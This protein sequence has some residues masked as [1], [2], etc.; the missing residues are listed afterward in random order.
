M[1]KKSMIYVWIFTFITILLN[2]PTAPTYAVSEKDTLIVGMQD[3]TLSLDPAKAYEFVSSGI[4]DQMY[5]RLVTLNKNDPSRVEPQLAESW[6]ISDDGKTWTFYLRKGVT[7]A[8]GNPVNAD[9]VVFSLGRVVKLANEV[10][11]LLTQ[12]GITESS[13]TKI[14]EYTVQTVLDDRYAPGI[15][16]SCL[17]IQVGSILDPKIVMEHEQDG[18]MG[19]AWLEEHSA[20]S[21]LFIL[22]Q[23]KH[24]ESYTLTQN[25]RYWGKKPA[26]KQIIVKNIQEPIDQMFMLEKGKIDIAWDLQPDQVRRLETNLD[27]QIYE[28]PTF[29]TIYVTMNQSYEPLKKPEVRDAIR[30]AIDYDGIIDFILQGA[31]VRAQTFLP[32]GIFNYTPALSYDYDLEKAKSLLTQAGYPDGFEVELACFDYSPWIDIAIKIKSDLTR[33]GINAKV[34]QMTANQLFEKSWSREGQ[35][36]LTYWGTDYVDPDAN[37][38]AFAHSDSPEDDATIQSVVWLTH[39][40]NLET[41]KLVGQASRELEPEK[42]AELYKEISDIILDDG[43]FAFLYSP[44]KQYGVRAEVRDVIGVPSFSLLYFPTLR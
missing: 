22:E 19:S 37:A 35:L 10:S 20:G 31:A 21:G 12:F 40:V 43:P 4:I 34:I 27:V 29:D 33:V 13:V 1:F 11:W 15:F 3:D 28:T 39:Y 9:A 6:K 2:L 18:D 44:L 23:R 5:E 42:R 8:S 17:A 16:L 25:E 30:Y 26:I 7:F 14:D 24:G 36:T 32:K 41:S 38:K